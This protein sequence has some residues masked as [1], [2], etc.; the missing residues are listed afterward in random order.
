[1]R[2]QILLILGI[3]LSS[4]S[5]QASFFSPAASPSETFVVALYSAIDN[6]TFDVVVPPITTSSDLC[7]DSTY[8]AT[9]FGVPV[10][11]NFFKIS[12]SSKG[13]YSFSFGCSDDACTN[14]SIQG[15]YDANDL[16]RSDFHSFE[17]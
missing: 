17:S 8:Y 7:F 3:L 4:L 5:V 6:V 10:L 9:M 15:T 16:V 13:I 11:Q 14:C 1:M 2:V 12:S